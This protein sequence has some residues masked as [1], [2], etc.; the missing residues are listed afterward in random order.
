[1]R[2]APNTGARREANRKSPGHPLATLNNYGLSPR[3]ASATAPDPLLAAA[4]DPLLLVGGLP[5]LGAARLSAARPDHGHCHAGLS[6]GVA[7]GG[8]RSFRV[9]VPRLALEHAAGSGGAAA[10]VANRASGLHRA[11]RQ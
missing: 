2:E 7:G 9:R 4:G 3:I 11:F 1:M 6:V 5:G 10:L 8:F